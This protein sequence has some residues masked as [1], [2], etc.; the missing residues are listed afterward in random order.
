VEHDSVMGFSWDFIDEIGV[1]SLVIG[2]GIALIGGY[3]LG[4]PAFAIG[5]LV[6]VGLDVA[7]VRIAT[8]RGRSALAEGSVDAVAP[9]LM[10]AGRLLAKTALL[11]IALFVP[12]DLAFAGTI[13][14]A[15]IFDVTLAFVGSALAAAR[16]MRHS[17]EGR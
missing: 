13:V 16:T 11:V 5:C 2:T 10:L 1:W 9:T 7:L 8:R 15:L 6:A 3:L 17:K 4:S 14:G 12:Q